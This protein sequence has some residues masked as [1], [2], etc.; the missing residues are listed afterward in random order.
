MGWRDR[1]R[2]PIVKE[3]GTS[4]ASAAALMARAANAPS[5]ASSADPRDRDAE[6]DGNRLTLLPDGPERLDALLDLINGA[7]ASLRMLYYM[8]HPDHS[9]ERGARRCC[10]PPGRGVEVS[11]LIDGFG[12]SATPDDSFAELAE[13][14][15]RFCRFNP[16]LRPA[17]SAAQP[18]EAG[19]RRCDD[20]RDPDRR[21]QHRR[22][23][24]RRPSGKALAR[25]LAAGRGPGRG[26]P[27]ALLR[28][29]LRLGAGEERRGSGAAPH[30]PPNISETR[31][32]LQWQF[33]GPERAISP[34]ACRTC[35]DLSTAATST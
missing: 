28:R 12:S 2:R 13:A 25:H 6:I 27:G 24:F 23:L 21:V 5:A 31:G 9:G 29:A 8:Y 30:G 11:L 10:R 14:G 32:P 20:D 26:A 3:I 34:W 4:Q 19:A 15:A 7:Q 35:R 33:G 1:A 16:S 22:Q 18:P 17:L